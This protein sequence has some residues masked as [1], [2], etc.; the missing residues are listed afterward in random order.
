MALDQHNLYKHSHYCAPC[1]RS[2]Q[3]AH[4]LETHVKFSDAHNPRTRKCPGKRC[5]KK[6]ITYADLALH[7]ESGK[8]R[9]RVTR[10]KINAIAVRMDTTNVI[11]NP[12]RLIAGPEGYSVNARIT[13]SYATERSYNGSAYECV[14][15]RKTF[16]TLDRLNQHLDSPVHD[17]EIYRCPKQY[18]GCNMEF[19]TLSALMQH[20]EKGSCGVQKYQ[21]QVNYALDEITARIGSIG[22]H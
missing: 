16:K 13:Q 2:F 17:D 3:T 10:G 21:K 7:L 20:A 15:C 14:L 12:N 9:C 19:R 5:N 11:T 6:F 22:F 8:C 1:K 4:A 18:A